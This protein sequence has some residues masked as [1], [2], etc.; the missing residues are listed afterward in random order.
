M[1]LLRRVGP[2]RASL[3]ATAS[4]LVIVIFGLLSCADESRPTPAARPSLPVSTVSTD[5]WIGPEG[6]TILHPSGAKVI[7]PP[8][9]LASATHLTLAGIK[10][11]VA[12]ALGGDPL[13]QGYAAGPDGQHFLKPVDVVVPFDPTRLAP[14]SD[15]THVQLRMAPNGSTD[16]VALQTTVD[17]RSRTL[18]A[19]TLHFT[20]FV[21]AA[22]PNPSS[23]RRRRPF[24]KAPLASRTHN[25]SRRQEV[26]R[27]TRGASPRAAH[28][29]PV[30]L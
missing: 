16:F 10:P 30:S 23:S 9:A 3:I 8:G 11:P 29:P 17:L 13:G 18:R 5:G 20:Q 1:R 28:C 27:L 21:P 6:G 26:R 14:G 25:S 4:L 15:V 12:A 22:N 2:L 19:S 7:V 24:R